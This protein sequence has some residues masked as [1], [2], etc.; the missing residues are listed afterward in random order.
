[1]VTRASIGAVVAVV[2]ALAGCSG[3][4]AAT[5]V[6]APTATYTQAQD[7]A[8]ALAGLSFDF[9]GDAPYAEQLYFST[10]G[11]VAVARKEA[12]TAA[13][14]DALIV[15]GFRGTGAD[16]EVAALHSA[17]VAGAASFAKTMT[18][19]QFNAAYKAIYDASQ[20]FSER[21]REIDSWVQQNVPR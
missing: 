9:G 13:K 21:C 15:A 17:L 3:E 5:P 1:M 7:D 14:K 10:L 16:A 4:A 11:D 6:P 2:L 8:C 12:A 18:I 20:A 19:D